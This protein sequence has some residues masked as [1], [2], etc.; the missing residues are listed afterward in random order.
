LRA[1]VCSLDGAE[2]VDGELIGPPEDPDSLGRILA[3]DLLARGGE[4][5][6]E[7]IRRGEG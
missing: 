3:G 4:A 7:K 5:I 2:A 1:V 6:L